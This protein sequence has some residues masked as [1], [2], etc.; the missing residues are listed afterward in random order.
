M[1][2]RTSRTPAS[3]GR[4]SGF[5][6]IAIVVVVA[7]AWELSP[8]PA[9]R[10]KICEVPEL[11]YGFTCSSSCE[12]ELVGDWESEFEDGDGFGGCGWPCHCAS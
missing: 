10:P 3:S 4:F 7:A 2:A 8:C 11:R 5:C 9:T 1:V 6:G 12:V